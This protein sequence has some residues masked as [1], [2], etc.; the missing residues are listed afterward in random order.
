MNA[1][2]SGGLGDALTY[3]V[4]GLAMKVHRALGPGLDEVFYHRLL[5]RQLASADVPHQFKP[6][7]PLI[8]QGEVADV[9]EPDLVIP[10]RLV[11]ELKAQRG[12][13]AA[14]SF[15]QLLSY[16]KFWRIPIGLL[17]EFSKERL[18]FQRVIRTEPYSI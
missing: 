1:A 16:L 13:L 11:I 9:F 4:I 8:Y 12:G 5:S 7:T 6:R 3:K 2:F 15:T 14:E 17:F 18:I 10:G